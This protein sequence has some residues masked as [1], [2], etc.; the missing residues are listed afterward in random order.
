VLARKI[1][2]QQPLTM[3]MSALTNDATD[4]DI[5]HH[6]FFLSEETVLENEKKRSSQGAIQCTEESKRLR[7]ELQELQ[8]ET[9]RRLDLLECVH[10]TAE[11]NQERFEEAETSLNDL[12]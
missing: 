10:E 5:L 6:D 8:Q 1:T 3:E 2:E 12:H 9:Q 7:R 11:G 4:E